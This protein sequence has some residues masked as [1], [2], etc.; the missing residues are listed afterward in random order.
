M[1]QKYDIVLL[2]ATSFTGG[3]M[4]EYM[5]ATFPGSLRWAIAARNK[6]KLEEVARKFNVEASGGSIIVLDV[7]SEAE[8]QK[9]VKST[10]VIINVIGPYPTTCGLIMIVTCGLD[11]V[12][13]DLTTYLAVSHIRRVFNTP[14]REVI[15]SLQEMK[16]IISSGTINSIASVYTL[17]GPGRYEEATAPFAISPRKPVSEKVNTSLFPAADF[18]GIHTVDGLGRVVESQEQGNER[19]I[20]GRSWG[21]YAPDDPN[22]TDGYGSNFHFSARARLPSTLYD[23]IQVLPFLGLGLF[24]NFSVTR[25]ILTRFIYPEGYT[26]TSK[27]LKGGHR[28]SHRTLA[29]ADTGDES[30]AK[31]VI[32]VF[33]FQGDQY[34]FTGIA[35]VQAAVTL[36]GGG[37]EA[38]RIGGGVMTPAMLG[39]NYAKNLQRPDSGV[40]ISIRAEG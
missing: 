5:T 36:L 21:L 1:Q 17:Y 34:K 2:G 39:D 38:H 18:F 28:F 33:K 32:V 31:R 24:L 20:V 9:V 6:A 19:A 27:Q 11:A 12:P 35:M 14:T 7:N 22:T 30:K 40:V 13:A 10:R 4:V 37:T 25:Y 23:F 16:G 26:P 8:I 15:V 3:L 29:V